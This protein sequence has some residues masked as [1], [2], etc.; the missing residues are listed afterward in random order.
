MRVTRRPTVISQLWAQ[1]R[2]QGEKGGGE[3]LSRIITFITNGE[4]RESTKTQLALVLAQGG[5]ATGRARAQNAPRPTCP[6]WARGPVA[7]PSGASHL[8]L[9]GQPLGDLRSCPGRFREARAQRREICVGR[10]VGSL[11]P[12]TPD[13]YCLGVGILEV[14]LVPWQRTE[15]IMVDPD[16]RN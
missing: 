5:S 3:N 4:H 2:E 6:R 16:F 1:N 13:V 14:P 8:R 7:P 10:W 15:F 12:F 9:T 11:S